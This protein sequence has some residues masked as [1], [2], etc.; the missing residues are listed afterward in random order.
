M[1]GEKG[2]RP[3]LVARARKTRLRSYRGSRPVVR[4]GAGPVRDNAGLLPLGV[5]EKMAPKPNDMVDTEP[6]PPHTRRAGQDNFVSSG[7]FGCQ[8]REPCRKP[9]IDC[10]NSLLARRSQKTR[11]AIARFAFFYRCSGER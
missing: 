6:Q 3:K 9:L 2:G 10:E 1:I 5:S 8:D 4:L 7:S 11:D